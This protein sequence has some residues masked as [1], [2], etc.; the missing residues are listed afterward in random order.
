M[1]TNLLKKISLLTI[2][3]VFIS[4]SYAQQTFQ[5]SDLVGKKWKHEYYSKAFWKVSKNK[6]FLRNESL[7]LIFFKYYLSDSIDTVF[8]KSKVGKNTQGK[9]IIIKFPFTK[10][11]IFEIKEILI[12]TENTLILQDIPDVIKI[13]GNSISVFHTKKWKKNALETENNDYQTFQQS[14][15]IEKKW[16]QEGLSNYPINFFRKYTNSGKV[17][18]IY[19][20]KIPIFASE[21]YL[22]DS[23]EKRPIFN[24]S[25]V[26]QNSKGKFIF[27][28]N[29][30]AQDG[31][32]IY[33]ILSVTDNRLILK[34]I[35]DDYVY[36]FYSN[37]DAN[38]HTEDCEQTD[39]EYKNIIPKT[40]QKSDIVGKKWEQ[41]CPDSEKIKTGNEYYLSDIIDT[42][43]Y[44]SK[45]GKST[46]GKYIIEYDSNGYVN[47]YQ[48]LKL[49]DDRLLIKYLYK[50]DY[51]GP[52]NNGISVY[53]IVEE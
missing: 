29:Q 2:C 24:V 36:V 11:S 3:V 4:N 44:K 20:E 8:D 45:I 13:G 10:D 32:K 42:V 6:A 30:Y 19:E 51:N 17:I 28:R 37:E 39:L 1:N 26:E 33:R 15:I 7:F 18:S 25:K 52:R 22:S 38:L 21:Y 34:G 48:I 14:D 41:K 16:K 12:L 50:D 27:F 31:M 47:V 46:R 49:T 23:I 40:F 9:Y 5:Q 53:H 43:F 35:P